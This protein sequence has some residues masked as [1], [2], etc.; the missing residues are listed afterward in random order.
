MKS[1]I[2]TLVFAVSAAFSLAAEPWPRFRGPEG[3]GIAADGQK[4]PVEFGPD[5]NLKWKVPAPSG[6]SSPI[7]VG[8]KLVITA[9]DD[10]KLYTIA[11]SRADGKELWRTEAPRQ[12][13]RGLSQ[14]RRKSRRFHLRD[15]RSENRFLLRFMRPVLLR[16]SGQ[17]T[18]ELS[19]AAR[20]NARRFRHGGLS[21]AG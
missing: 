14:N 13:D 6:F 2:A 17:G 7:V 16:S 20:A 19:D 21:G 11:Y 10:G 1:M 4:P 3:S 18:V 9:F 12:K 15:G 8:D 5:K